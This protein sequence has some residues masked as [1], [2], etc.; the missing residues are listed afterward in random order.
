MA[1]YTQQPAAAPEPVIGVTQSRLK[2]FIHAAVRE[3]TEHLTGGD[4]SVLP[5]VYGFRGCIRQT[6]AA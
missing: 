5:K 6:R 4:Q 2:A 1:D 3:T